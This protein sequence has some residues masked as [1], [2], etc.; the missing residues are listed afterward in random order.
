VYLD[1]TTGPQRYTVGLCSLST[2][3]RSAVLN[4]GVSIEVT[5]L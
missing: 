3:D 5:Y 4:W 2:I 1:T